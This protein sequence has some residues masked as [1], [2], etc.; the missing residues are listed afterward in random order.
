MKLKSSLKDFTERSG[1]IDVEKDG[2]ST[3][4][5]HLNL[6]LKDLM[7]L[8]VGGIIVALGVAVFI[9]PHQI[10]PG[11]ASGIAII[12][13]SFIS[14]PIGLLMLALNIPAFIL[15]FRRL[16]GGSFLTRSIVGTLAYNL[17]VDL[18]G[19]F[20]PPGGVTD[21]MILNAIFGGIVSGLGIGLIYRAG[22]V[23][24]A[25]G[26]V[27]RL[28]R[29]KLSW[30]MQT[31]TL[32]TNGSVVIAA[33]FV[34]GWEA[35]MYAVISFFVSGGVADFILEGPDVVQTAFIVTDHPDQMSHA[36]AGELRR[37][38]PGGR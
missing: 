26:V 18:I 32:L 14:V 19:S 6:A 25:G 4:R 28:L 27:N 34:F 31:V 35:A 36:L 33:G 8:I 11:G 2:R 21:E 1:A 12:L 29:Q 23:A 7:Q 15:G 10:A 38:G 9:A 30:P 5:I 17:T 24:G 20:V 16:G 22:G 37:G 13:N 3:H